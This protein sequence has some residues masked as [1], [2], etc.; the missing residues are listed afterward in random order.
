MIIKKYEETMQQDL[1]KMLITYLNDDLKCDWKERFI[2]KRIFKLF[3]EKW[4]EEVVFIDVIEEDNQLVGFA[5]YQIDTPQSDWC[6]KQGWGFIREV[7]VQK[8][9]RG[10]GYGYK[11]AKEVEQV[12]CE[13]NIKDV[14]LKTDDAILFWE[15]CNY[16]DIGEVDEEGMHTLTKKISAMSG[17]CDSEKSAE[18][19]IYVYCL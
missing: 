6:K 2:E 19:S 16:V 1:L 10:L 7:Y 8:E 3:E 18:V 4:R 9:Y 13:K 14:Y 11:L 15:K 17:D 12:F 5:I